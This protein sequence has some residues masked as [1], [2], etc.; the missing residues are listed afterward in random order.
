MSFM[1]DIVCILCT[2]LSILGILIS[3]DTMIVNE[4]IAGIILILALGIVCK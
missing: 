4:L 1:L 2:I 3:T